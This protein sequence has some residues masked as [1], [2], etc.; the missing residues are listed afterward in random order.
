MEKDVT[1]AD[2][3]QGAH[4]MVGKLNLILAGTTV[5]YLMHL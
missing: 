5:F 3:K 2:N 4:L 1:N